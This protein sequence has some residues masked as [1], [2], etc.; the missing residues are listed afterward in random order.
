MAGVERERRLVCPPG[1][2]RLS[3]ERGGV[4]E[5]V[6]ERRVARPPAYQPHQHLVRV[7]ELPRVDQRERV[8]A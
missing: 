2:V 5:L 3:G 1:L 6:V 8:G 4:G 7:G